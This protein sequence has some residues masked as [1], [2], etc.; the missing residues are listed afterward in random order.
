MRGFLGLSSSGHTTV[1]ASQQ[2]GGCCSLLLGLILLIG[3]LAILAGVV[4]S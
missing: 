3:L 4:A 2:V 1:G